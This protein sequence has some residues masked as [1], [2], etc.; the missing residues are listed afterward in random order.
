M[1][2]R[3]D[4]MGQGPVIDPVAVLDGRMRTSFS[5]VN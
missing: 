2:E 1:N 3:L 4:V 5:N